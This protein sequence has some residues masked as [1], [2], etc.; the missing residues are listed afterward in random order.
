MS[1]EIYDTTTHR[2]NVS[3]GKFEK[4]KPPKGKEKGRKAKIKRNYRSVFRFFKQRGNWV[5][6]E[7]K[8]TK[9]GK[10]GEEKAKVVARRVKS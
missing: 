8:I 4:R 2:W 9:I 3:K 1:V 5:P 6:N 7:A 10:V